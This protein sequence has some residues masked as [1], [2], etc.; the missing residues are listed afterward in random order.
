MEDTKSARRWN[1]AV[2]ILTGMAVMA[3]TLGFVVLTGDDDSAAAVV[4]TTAAA[5]P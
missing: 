5:L 1:L 3:I 2:G 4:A